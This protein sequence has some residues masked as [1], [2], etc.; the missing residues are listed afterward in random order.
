MDGVVQAL[1]H[2]AEG[3]EA[4]VAAHEEEIE[5]ALQE[6]EDAILKC[7]KAARARDKAL[8][9][10]NQCSQRVAS[11]QSALCAAT[12][13]IGDL[14]SSINTPTQASRKRELARAIKERDDAAQRVRDLEAALREKSQEAAAIKNQY[15]HRLSVVRMATSGVGVLPP[16]AAAPQPSPA[17]VAEMEIPA[18]ERLRPAPTSDASSVRRIHIL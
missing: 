18:A 5:E 14:R 9:A 13:A 7:K 10:S 3:L 4:T 16:P 6:K 17:A 1:S 2:L 11:V 12:K 15:E 8:A